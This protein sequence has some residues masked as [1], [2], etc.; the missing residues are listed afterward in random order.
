MVTYDFIIIFQS[1]QIERK[2]ITKAIQSLK[3]FLLLFFTVYYSNEKEKFNVISS[4][5]KPFNTRS[6]FYM[7]Y[8]VHY[9]FDNEIS[10]IYL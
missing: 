1:H 6:T 3:S 8:M 5:Y 4:L 7:Y 2:N 10:T 9:Y